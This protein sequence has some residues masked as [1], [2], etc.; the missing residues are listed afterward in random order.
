[1]PV[2]GGF[3]VAA[4]STKLFNRNSPIARRRQALL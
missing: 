4:F 2:S 3:A 1:M